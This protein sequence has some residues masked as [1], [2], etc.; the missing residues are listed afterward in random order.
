MA[1]APSRA[2]SNKCRSANSDRQVGSC[3]TGS[4]WLRGLYS[5]HVSA[6]PSESIGDPAEHRGCVL[7]ESNTEKDS[8]IKGDEEMQHKVP[9]Q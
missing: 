8:E 7:A 9:E 6:E 1:R 2:G 3:E 5:N 4:P